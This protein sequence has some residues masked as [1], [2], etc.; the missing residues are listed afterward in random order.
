MI[1][2]RPH[3]AHLAGEA[4]HGLGVTA[5]VDPASSAATQDRLHSDGALGRTLGSAQ[6]L[7]LVDLPHVASA[8]DPA[9]AESAVDE[10][11]AHCPLLCLLLTF[12]RFRTG[13]RPL[14][15]VPHGP[16]CQNGQ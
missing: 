8:D 14:A 3:D 6:V 13:T 11:V 2:Q 4:L 10:L 16:W 15:L 9:D 7:G 12:S 5:G 1:P